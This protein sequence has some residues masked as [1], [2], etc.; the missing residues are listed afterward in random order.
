M[1]AMRINWRRWGVVTFVMV[2]A[3]AVFLAQRKIKIHTLVLTGIPARPAMVG[4]PGLDDALLQGEE[5]ARS[6]LH[7][8]S[9]LVALSR[10]Y[11]ANGFF[12]ESIQCYRVLSRIEPESARWDHL[13]ANILAGFGRLDEALP[14]EQRAVHLA[15]TYI[16][17]RLRL[18]DIL[19]KLN[20]TTPAVETYRQVLERDHDNPY[21][22]LGLAKCAL[23]V[24]DWATA[25]EN[26]RKC[27]SVH[28]AFIGG[29]SLSATVAEHFGDQVEAARL[30]EEIGRKEF[31]DLPDPWLDDLLSDCYDPYRLSV[32]ATVAKM[33]G[34][35]SKA[36][37]L[38]ERATVLAPENS[39][40]HRQLG[41]LL[42]QG[43]DSEAARRE[44]ERAVSLAPRD[45]DAWL[46]LYQ[47]L[48]KLGDTSAAARAIT[49]GLLSCPDSASLH[50][51]QARRWNTSGHPT[52]AAAEFREAY[53][54]NPSEA[55]A[56]IELASTL[57]GLGQEDEALASLRLA[58]EKQPE[59][60][61]AL[62]TLTFYYISH[63]DETEALAWWQHVRHQPRTLPRTVEALQQAFRQHFGHD[64]P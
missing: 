28:P 35:L 40:Y 64:L 24:K 51:E 34:D 36:K 33:V 45:V 17:A 26:L 14:L 4:F 16:P 8:L 20:Q 43:I 1:M 12:D 50:L 30:R 38:L 9:G 39:S 47:L 25:R 57:F 49:N 59:N 58:L 6:Y 31:S 15:D 3:C 53:R 21:A 46:L 55:Q 11:H 60:P 56:L 2:L 52:Q 23:T 5:S 13:Q 7:S 37:S 41:L 61:M 63:G 44:L 18:G 62:S 48:T 32:V 29:M 54:L 27:I 42:S 19:L 22:L 10:L